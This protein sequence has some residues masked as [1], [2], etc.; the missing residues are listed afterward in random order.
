M[1]ETA[2]SKP[3]DII[4][5]R[6]LASESFRTSDVSLGLAQLVVSRERLGHGA[7]EGVVSR[8]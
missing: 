2:I 8:L 5:Y 3:L 6:T 4:S 1:Y 7:A